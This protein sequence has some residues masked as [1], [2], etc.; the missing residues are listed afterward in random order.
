MAFTVNIV[1]IGLARV[2]NYTSS[3]TLQIMSL[4]GQTE[5]HS[6]THVRFIYPSVKNEEKSFYKKM[7]LGRL[8]TL[9]AAPEASLV[10]C[11]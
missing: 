10:P 4:H 11:S 9:V 5:G 2:D 3:V 7:K 1:N 8:G 6:L